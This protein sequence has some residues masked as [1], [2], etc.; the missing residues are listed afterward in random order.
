MQRIFVHIFEE[1]DCASRY[2]WR[3]R[4]VS[5][6]VSMIYSSGSMVTSM[7]FPLLIR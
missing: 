1:K 6:F 3:N 4:Y 5:I 7:R 2:G